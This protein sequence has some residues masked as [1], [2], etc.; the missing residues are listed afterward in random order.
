[1]MTKDNDLCTRCK[2][3]KNLC[4]AKRCPL[5]LKHK[6]LGEEIPKIKKRR[7][8]VV[9]RP[10]FLVGEYGYPN[11]TLG[12]L[13]TPSR[14]S[15]SP[16]D[17]SDWAATGKKMADILKIRLG[18]LFSRTKARVKDARKRR[19]IQEMSISNKPLDVE[20]GLKKKPKTKAKLDAEIPPVG[21]SGELEDIK[22]IDNISAPR[23]V[24]SAVEE[25]A[26]VKRIAPEL[27]K[28]DVSYYK[29]M[30]LLSTGMLG[31]KRKRKFVPTRWA[32]T[33]TDNILGDYFL[34]EIKKYSSIGVGNLYF[35]KYLGNLYYLI[36]APS[37]CWR[38]E[39]FEIWLPNS[40]WTG[41]KEA[42]VYQIHEGYD[43][44]PTRMDGG[45]YA[46]R[47]GILE[48]LATIQKK[49]AALAVRIITPSYYAPVGSW[50]IRESV[51]L[52]LEKTPIKKG[53][54]EELL[55]YITTKEEGN[56][57]SNLPKRSWL[58]KKVKN[59]T[60]DEFLPS[61]TSKENSP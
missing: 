13:S 6:Y 11:V 30:R 24:E 29:I 58:L 48:H 25:D 26:V 17:P 49:A 12:P 45:Y 28:H 34:G 51:R 59:P 37:D 22:I 20:V 18:T 60:L 21:L 50:Q 61:S 32:I 52:A 35:K 55:A 43:G 15:I 5:L 54:L 19:K 38:M 10:D 39:M 14:F 9:S 27:W 36:L 53:R 40:V 23:K 41:S 44:N 16:Q 1:M 31:L 47:Y 46:I 3:V 7:L 56:L 8:Q 33:A 4:G 57:P 2:G 42:A